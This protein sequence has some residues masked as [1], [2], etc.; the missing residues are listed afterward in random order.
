MR[1]TGKSRSL[2]R[3]LVGGITTMIVAGSTVV[4]AGEASAKGL[5]PFANMAHDVAWRAVQ[6]EN[7]TSQATLEQY[8]NMRDVRRLMCS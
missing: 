6:A 1:I 5:C 4:F 3:V 2:R 7:P 8:R